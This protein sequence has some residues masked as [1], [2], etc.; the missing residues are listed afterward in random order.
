M[1]NQNNH[2]V[3]IHFF[4][5]KSNQIEYFLVQARDKSHWNGL[6]AEV[7]SVKNSRD[8]NSKFYEASVK[9]T[10]KYPTPMKIHQAFAGQLTPSGYIIVAEGLS[11][12][13][14]NTIRS[15]KIEE[16]ETLFGLKDYKLCPHLV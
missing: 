10:N 1:A 7:H 14:A 15:K 11:K 13:D 4:K 8:E 2:R 16:L 9:G 3:V 5:D 12:A 6:D